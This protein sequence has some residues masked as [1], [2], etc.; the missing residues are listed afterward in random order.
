MSTVTL[1]PKRSKKGGVFA[2]IQGCDW[3]RPKIP[4]LVLQELPFE[5]IDHI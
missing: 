4:T 5:E 1:L 3:L 2:V